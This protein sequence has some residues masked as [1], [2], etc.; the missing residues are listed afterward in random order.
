VVDAEALIEKGLI[1]DSKLPVKIL[2]NG[3][4]TRKLTVLAGWYSKSA[5]AK[6]AQ[7]GGTAQTAKGT[8]FEFPKPKKKFI[9]RVPVKKVKL[10]DAEASAPAGKPE[11]GKPEGGKPDAAKPAEAAPA[12]DS[13]TVPPET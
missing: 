7:A 3:D 4:L 5:H 1:P 9:P 11:A 10:D 12:A 6:I 13:P 2:G 8:T